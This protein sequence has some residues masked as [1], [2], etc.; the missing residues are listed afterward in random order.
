MSP[1]MMRRRVDFPQ[2]LGPMT[3][4]KLPESTEKLRWSSTGTAMVLSRTVLKKVLPMFSICNLGTGAAVVGVTRS[5][6][7]PR[8]VLRAQRLLRERRGQRNPQPLRERLLVDAPSDGDVVRD[9]PGGMDEDA[10][11][12]ALAARPEPG[13]HL[14]DIGVQPFAIELAGFDHVAEL[15]H[16]HVA[17]PVV[18]DRLVEMRPARRVHLAARQRDEGCPALYPGLAADDVG[19]GGAADGDIGIA[20]DL[21]DAVERSHRD[22][23]RL[24]PLR[25]E[26]FAGLLAA[27]GADDLV[28]AVEVPQAAQAILRHGADTDQAQPVRRLRPQPLER[29]H[30]GCRAADGVGPVLVHDGDRLPG[31]GIGQHDVARAVE[32]ADGVSHA[33]VII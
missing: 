29:D 30:G 6:S 12:V 4:T 8:S 19:A 24:R 18:D 1:S 23:E 3:E 10:L 20:H 9:H 17:V 11:V 22:A 28:E 5:S 27:R 14:A 21:L 31:A 25:R 32:P 2:P 26:G 16:G 13:D 7:K 33:V 15:A